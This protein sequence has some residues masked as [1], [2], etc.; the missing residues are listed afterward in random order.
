MENND[1]CSQ[2]TFFRVP[3]PKEDNDEA[4]KICAFFKE[5]IGKFVEKVKKDTELSKN[6]KE[7]FYERTDIL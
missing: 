1:G 7:V 2:N 4:K 5:F 6:L 3:I